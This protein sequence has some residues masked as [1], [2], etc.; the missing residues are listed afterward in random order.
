MANPAH[1]HVARLV[2]SK[3]QAR[4]EADSPQAFNLAT[5]DILTKKGIVHPTPGQW[6]KAARQARFL[7]RR[8]G[9][10]GQFITHSE[11]GILKGPGGICYRCGGNGTQDDRDVI[12]NEHYDRYAFARAARY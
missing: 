6:I 2:Y 9:G 8:C 12:R 10:T 7:C 5:R 1:S 4:S 3:I 11:N